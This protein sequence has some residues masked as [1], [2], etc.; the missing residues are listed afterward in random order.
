M[1]YCD[2]QLEQSKDL[3]DTANKRVNSTTTSK[4]LTVTTGT[5]TVDMH[6][7]RH[8]RLVHNDT[9]YGKLRHVHKY[10]IHTQGDNT[11]NT[12]YV[13]NWRHQLANYCY[14]L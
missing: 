12:D 9:N 13:H 3:H 10:I 2:Q 5:T 4:L 14:K 11:H 8:Q 6:Y 1:Q 7:W